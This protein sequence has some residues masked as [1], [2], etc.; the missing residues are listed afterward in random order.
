MS[1]RSPRPT[2]TSR[3]LEAQA[4]HSRPRQPP[5]GRC[6]SDTAKR[7][8]AKRVT[9]TARSAKRPTQKA[10]TFSEKLRFIRRQEPITASWIERMVDAIYHKAMA[11][12]VES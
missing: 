7:P 5:S 4:A 1:K 3:G 9:R 2:P 10:P 6:A 12:A 8:A 11:G